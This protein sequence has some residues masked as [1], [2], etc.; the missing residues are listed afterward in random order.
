[1]PKQKTNSSVRKRFKLTK[2][3]KLRRNKAFRRHLLAG[4]TT[5][6]KRK[7]RRPGLVSAAESRTY[8]R[9]LGEG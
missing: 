6:R 2:G 7:L 3:R 5:K 4:R 8:L 1:M 9:L